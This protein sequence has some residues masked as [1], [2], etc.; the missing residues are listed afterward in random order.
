MWNMSQLLNGVSAPMKRSELRW[1]E[2][3]SLWASWSIISSVRWAWASR[4]SWV[5]VGCGSGRLAAQLSAFPS[6]RFVGCDV[7]PRLLSYAKDICQRDDWRFVEA[8]GT[9]IPCPD[10]VADFVCFFSV[11]THLCQEDIFRYLCE[12]RRVLKPGGLVVAW[13]GRAS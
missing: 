10:G 9:A 11:F 6:V 2:N 12:A 5:D 1:V 4:S 13:I 3:L 7:V 8:T